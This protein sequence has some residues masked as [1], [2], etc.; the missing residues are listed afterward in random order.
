MSISA[1]PGQPSIGETLSGS[2]RDGV[3]VAKTNLVPGILLIVAGT[4]L[5][6]IL[7][8]SG[9]FQFGATTS[10]ANMPS[11]FPALIA[12]VDLLLVVVSYY[13][14]AA[15]IRTIHTDYRM[16]VGQFFGILGYSLL[17]SLLACIAAI[18]FIIPAYWVGVKLAVTPYAYAL[19]AR[20][21]LKTTWNM[22]TGY[23]W[24]TLGM[25]LL[26]GICLGIIGYIAM[27][28]CFFGVSH[29]PL[30]AIVLGPLAG[31]VFVWLVH[32]QALV[33][34]RWTNGLLPR[35]NTPQ[36]VPTPA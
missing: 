33:Y 16:T 1:P 22:T 34:V 30:S 29:A 3:S 19:G 9:A 28:V 26:A 7:G 18:F 23:Y 6:Y 20:D 36:A 10:P 25:F 8:S 17:V 31:A 13:A 12:V 27:L 32:V 5:V 24:Q 14:I 21:P 35:A 11:A 2:F 4:I 15:A